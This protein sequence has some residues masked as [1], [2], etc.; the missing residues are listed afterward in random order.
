MIDFVQ[1][2]KKTSEN[3][4][5]RDCIKRKNSAPNSNHQSESEENEGKRSRFNELKSQ[6]PDGSHE[7]K[8]QSSRKSKD[9]PNGLVSRSIAF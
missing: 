3:S 1:I 2:G 9:S 8:K 7:R 6:S 4:N 5:Q